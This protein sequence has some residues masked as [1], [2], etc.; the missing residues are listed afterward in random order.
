MDSN[1]VNIVSAEKE[2]KKSDDIHLNARVEEK[3]EETEGIYTE[4]TS[5]NENPQSIYS[6]IHPEQKS[7]SLLSRAEKYNVFK[8]GKTK[9]RYWL[10]LIILA[11]LLTSLISGAV[12][13]Y[14][15]SSNKSYAIQGDFNSSNEEFMISIT[16]K[17]EYIENNT[18]INSLKIAYIFKEF[19]QLNISSSIEH[20]SLNEK[21][22]IM[23]D[24]YGTNITSIMDLIID[25]DLQLVDLVDQLNTSSRIEYASLYGQISQVNHLGK[26]MYFPAPSCRAIY[27]LQPYSMSGYY[28][29]SSFD[30]ASVRVYCEMTK[31]CGNVTGGLTRVAVLNDETR[32]S[33]CTGDFETVNHDT[34]CI[35]NTEEP[36]CSH[37]VFPLMDMS[38]S[39]IC[40]TVE[41]YWFGSPDG[42]SRPYNATI[43]DN[44]VDGIS[45]AYGNTTNRIHIWTFIADG[46]HNT[47]QNCPRAV[48]EY[49][50]NSYSCLI[51]DRLCPSTTNPCSHE[52]FR[53]FQQAVTE[54]IK[55]RLCRDQHRGRDE[56]IYVGNLEIF[57]W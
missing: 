8:E 18:L 10:C 36:G 12:I 9:F 3:D 32:P 22:N 46:I 52:F 38:Y 35:R 51:D 27:L 41:G 50:G 1:Y 55:M 7:D 40:G 26:T 15:V 5:T 2:Q 19:N 33:I 30:G 20:T 6:A 56:G 14:A 28:W 23:N 24:V 48:P 34:R 29:V 49:V 37:M 42:F 17:L 31:F 54:D 16:S 47:R 45:L 57:V 21:I 43:N 13:S 4:I 39:H 25:R 11:Q 44:Y 53:N